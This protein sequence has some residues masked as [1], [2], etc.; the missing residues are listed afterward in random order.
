MTMDHG[1]NFTNP[2]LSNQYKCNA[3]LLSHVHKPTSVENFCN[4]VQATRLK[5]WV[6]EFLAYSETKNK[7]SNESRGDD[8][9]DDDSLLS[10]MSRGKQARV[11]KCV[12][13]TG[14]PGVGKTSLVYT[15]AKELGLHVTESHSS[16]KRDSKVFSMLKLTNQ[17]GRI[18]PIALMFQNA[19]KTQIKQVEEVKK[20]SKLSRKKRKMAN[21]SIGI[22]VLS[23]NNLHSIKPSNTLSISGDSSII[24]FDDVDVVF[25]EDGPFLKSILEFVKTSERPVI[26]TA[27]QFTDKIIDTFSESL[28]LIRLERPSVDYCANLLHSICKSEKYPIL[29][30]SLAS[31]K[32]IAKQNNCDVRRCLNNIHYFGKHT[33][34]ELMLSYHDRSRRFELDFV[35]FNCFPKDTDKVVVNGALEAYVNEQKELISLVESR[36]IVDLIE[37]EYH[38]M[39]SRTHLD[40]WIEGKLLTTDDVD[41]NSINLGEQIL[42]T[43]VNLVKQYYNSKLLSDDNIAKKGDLR[44]QTREDLYSGRWKLFDIINSR[45]EIYDEAFHTDMCPYVTQIIQLEQQR[46]YDNKNSGNEDSTPTSYL[47]RNRRILD[48]LDSIE[49]YIDQQDRQNLLDYNLTD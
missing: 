38:I 10:N 6:Q 9:S 18:N 31:C 11:K 46:K 22:S 28:E 23:S 19:G 48:Y 36:Q 49:F 24:L 15:V 21:E 16:D 1:I 13:V 39:D 41:Y 3:D 25:D 34:N 33:S 37:K 7:Q 47:R 43:T 27:T 45:I 30:K 17:K 8:F 2:K 4:Q 44:R 40:Q 35:K 29:A 42:D 20:S 32:R 14:P 26:L 12:L 5:E